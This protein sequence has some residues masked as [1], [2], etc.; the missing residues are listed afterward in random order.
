MGSRAVLVVCR[1]ADEARRRFGISREGDEGIGTCVTRTGRR[2]FDDPALERGLLL[3]VREALDRSGLWERLETGW[4]CLDAE[5]MPWSVKAQ[6]LIREQYASV[7]AAA[8]I[9]LPKV[10][11]RLAETGARGLDTGELLARY[12]ERYELSKRFADAYRRYCWPVAS[13]ADLRLAPFHLLASEGAV[14][15]DKDHVWQMETL[16]EVCRADPELLVATPYR[17]VDLADPASEAAATGWWEELTGKGGEGMVVKP[18][19]FVARGRRGFAQPAL[20]CRGREYLRIIYGPEYTL[21]DNLERLRQRGLGAKRSLAMREFALGI[22]GLER[23]VNREPLRR[24]HE[25]VF[26]VL[27]LESEPVDPRL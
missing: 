27:A 7:G 20:K 13:V 5:L 11:A 26:G 3:R 14:H 9:A 19:D 1:D 4:V 25:C 16:A 17:V 23:F 6:E 24:V 2:F 22:E 12:R 18:F 8:R 10:I 21:P 15:I